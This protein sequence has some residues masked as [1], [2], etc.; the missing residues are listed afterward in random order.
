MNNFTEIL[1]SEKTNEINEHLSIILRANKT[2]FL[3]LLRKKPN[4][5][6]R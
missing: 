3:K 4:E 2:N 6:G 5:M 1:S